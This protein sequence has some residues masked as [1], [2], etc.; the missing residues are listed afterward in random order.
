[1]FVAIVTVTLESEPKHSVTH[2]PSYRLHRA[3]LLFHINTSIKMCLK[4]KEIKQPSETYENRNQYFSM[5]SESHA[6]LVYVIIPQLARYAGNKGYKWDF[7]WFR[8]L[9]CL[10]LCQCHTVLMTAVLWFILKS[11]FVVPP[12]LL[13]FPKNTLAI[14]DLL[15][16]HTYF[17]IICFSFVKKC[18][19]HFHRDWIESRLLSIIWLFWQY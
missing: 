5:Q 1:M 4:V 6:S 7:I 10:F 8:W 2:L 9:M 15:W 12:T 11:G 19:W 14:W 18:H 17:S 3:Q 13:L 16:F